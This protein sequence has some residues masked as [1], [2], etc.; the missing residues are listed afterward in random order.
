MTVSKDVGYFVWPLT[1]EEKR[2]KF[3][4][5]KLTASRHL[6]HFLHPAYYPGM[7]VCVGVAPVGC[8][9]ALAWLPAMLRI[10]D[11][12]IYYFFSAEAATRGRQHAE[13]GRSS[14]DDASVRPG[15]SNKSPGGCF[16]L[17]SRSQFVVLCCASAEFVL[18]SNTLSHFRVCKKLFAKVSAGTKIPPLDYWNRLE[19]V[20]MDQSQVFKRKE[21]GTKCG[22]GTSQ[23]FQGLITP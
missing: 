21:A 7:C 6:H 4:P 11:V 19:P 13:V 15:S 3:S 9:E 20:G 5:C 16:S 18:L 14:A 2:Q 12:L 1:P 17:L 8:C 10:C 22:V 23:V